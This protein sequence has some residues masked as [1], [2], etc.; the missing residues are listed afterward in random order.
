MT[1]PRSS[2]CTRTSRTRPRRSPRLSTRTSSGYSTMPRTRCSRASSSTSVPARRLRVGGRRCVG[3]ASAAGASAAASAAAWPPQPA[4]EQPA[5]LSRLRSLAFAARRPRR[6]P[7]LAAGASAA[8]GVSGALPF[9][10]ASPVGLRRL[11]PAAFAVASSRRPSPGVP[12][13]LAALPDCSPDFALAGLSALARRRVLARLPPCRTSPRRRRS[14]CCRRTCPGPW[15]G[16]PVAQG[17]LDRGGE[18]L[19]AVL[20]GRRHLQRSL[21]TRAGP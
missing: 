12:P 2:G 16:G 8:G 9:A 1:L 5:P 14:P 13:A 19:L 4:L 3:Q 17:L 15:R 20:L 11:V 10:V 7:G 18:D 21:G 6:Q